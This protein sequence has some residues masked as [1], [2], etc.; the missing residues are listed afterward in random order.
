[1]RVLNARILPL[2]DGS[3]YGSEITVKV[4]DDIGVYYTEIE[5]GVS[6]GRPSDRWL[7]HCGYTKEDWDNN[8][9]VED[10][11]G[12]KAPIQSELVCD[13]HYETQRTWELMQKVI[14]S[15]KE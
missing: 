9:M 13:A 15:L 4:I 10:G 2:E 1:M 8:I 3:Y 6:G 14:R 7:E 11:Y 5:F 12:G